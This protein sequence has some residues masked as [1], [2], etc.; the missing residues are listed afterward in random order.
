MTGGSIR[1]AVV[2]FAAG[3][4]AI[5]GAAAEIAISSIPGAEPWISVVV[6]LV[7]PVFAALAAVHGGM[8][9][10]HA[11]TWAVP[12]SLLLLLVFLRP[13]HPVMLLPLS[14]GMGLPALMLWSSRTQAAWYRV[15][16][17]IPMGPPDPR[18]AQDSSGRSSGDITGR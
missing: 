16:L 9:P 17:R 11:L 12:S 13:A 14:L 4:L 5:A 6:A 8:R 10:T 1:L 2:V 15:V 18:S 7:V 3:L